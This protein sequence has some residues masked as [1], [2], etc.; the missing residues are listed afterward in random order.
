MEGG[1]L[2]FPS[3]WWTLRLYI[4]TI[5]SRISRRDLSAIALLGSSSGRPSNRPS[6]LWF[7]STTEE[8]KD[9]GTEAVWVRVGGQAGGQHHSLSL[10][11]LCST[12]RVRIFTFSSC[13]RGRLGVIRLTA[14]VLRKRLARPSVGEL[15][16]LGLARAPPTA[17]AANGLCWQ[18]QN[19]THNPVN[20]LPPPLCCGVQTLHLCSSALLILIQVIH[21]R[22]LDLCRIDDDVGLTG[23]VIW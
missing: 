9:T 12:A 20:C 21:G 7:P 15:N 8:E 14:A 1:A 18:R 22:G 10:S 17:A 3:C 5:P 16:Q 11:V 4:I 2:T 23:Q 6:W 19:R 13:I